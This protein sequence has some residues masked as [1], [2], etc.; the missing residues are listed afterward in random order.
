MKKSLFQSKVSEIAH[1]LKYPEMFSGYFFCNIMVTFIVYIVYIYNKKH[2]PMNNF[3]ILK[4]STFIFFF[5]SIMFLTQA[6][7]RWT[8]DTLMENRS[9]S[10]TAVLGYKIYFFSGS[11]RINNDAILSTTMEI[12]DTRTG[13]KELMNIPEDAERNGIPAVS[14]GSKLIFSG[15]AAWPGMTRVDIYD[16]LTGEWTHTDMAEPKMQHAATVL[17]NKLYIGGGFDGDE[18]YY[19]TMN[20]Y[21]I[22]QDTWETLTWTSWGAVGG[23]LSRNRLTSVSIDDLVIFAGG[24]GL[25]QMLDH[26]VQIYTIQQRKLS[27]KMKYRRLS[28]YLRPVRI[29]AV[30][31]MMVKPGLL[32]GV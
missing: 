21:D 22:E 27:K 8:T 16:T 26:L 19:N 32:G 13:E 28:L 3:S 9:I 4:Y 15:G 25:V 12:H 2:I 17:D 7:Q 31:Y 24:G 14:S 5:L 29:L 18:S 11:A 23:T 20:I 1:Y 6:Q 30:L 10:N